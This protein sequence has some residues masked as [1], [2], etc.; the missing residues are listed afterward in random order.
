[1]TSFSGHGLFST[2][3]L[4][5]VCVAYHQ[6]NAKSISKFHNLSLPLDIL[7]WALDLCIYSNIYCFFA[8]AL[9]SLRTISDRLIY[10][11]CGI[12]KVNWWFY[13]PR[14]TISKITLTDEHRA[15]SG[16]KTRAIYSMQNRDVQ[17]WRTPNKSRMLIS[18]HKKRYT[19]DQGS[20][21]QKKKKKTLYQ[22]KRSIRDIRKST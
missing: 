14:S 3:W 5:N 16:N 13:N 21:L 4:T 1:M 20:T 10:Q 6:R 2:I 19:I 8:F 15:K 22:I 12:Q 9:S 7:K 11:W 17:M 18:C